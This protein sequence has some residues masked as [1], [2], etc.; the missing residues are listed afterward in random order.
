MI[1]R[2]KNLRL[3]I[4]LFYFFTNFETSQTPMS[5]RI[6]VLFLGV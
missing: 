1:I 6:S 5:L 2:Q 4:G 3:N